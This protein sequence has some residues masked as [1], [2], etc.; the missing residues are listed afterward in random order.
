[1]REGGLR[2][3]EP[4]GQAHTAHRGREGLSAASRL[5]C[6][7]PPRKAGGKERAGQKQDEEE[8][9]QQLQTAGAA[10]AG[11]VPLTSSHPPL[12]SPTLKLRNRGR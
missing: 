3:G 11:C 12:L 1:M 6:L 7:Q 8:R 9:H 5:P 4:L 10:T 2:E